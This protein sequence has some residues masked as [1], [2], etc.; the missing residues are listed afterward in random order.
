MICLLEKL[1]ESYRILAFFEKICYNVATLLKRGKT[2][3]CYLDEKDFRGRE[4]YITDVIK[5]KPSGDDKQN[6]STFTVRYANGDFDRKVLNTKGNREILNNILTQQAKNGV[7]ARAKLVK[8]KVKD[9]AAY[10]GSSACFCLGGGCGVGGAISTH[11]VDSVPFY[12]GVVTAGVL[13]IGAI[14]LTAKG[15]KKIKAVN[16]MIEEIDE[17]KARIDNTKTARECLTTSSNAYLALEG[18]SEEEKINRAGKL[19]DYIDAG[20]DPFSFLAAE[21]GEGVTTEEMGHLVARRARE[22]K[23]GLA[24]GQGYSYQAVSKK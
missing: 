15:M 21:L 12:I 4:L 3:K 13:G 2:M 6:D 18:Q 8:R 7:L 23:I 19:F 22:K 11:G 24:F 10:L 17:N 5:D 20:G 9:T 1:S 16:G 14:M